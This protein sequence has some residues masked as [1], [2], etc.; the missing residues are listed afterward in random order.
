MEFSPIWIF[1]LV[2]LGVKFYYLYSKDKKWILIAEKLS[3]RLTSEKSL[4]SSIPILS[5]LDNKK[6]KGKKNGVS[7][8]IY[9]ET[10][11]SGK[12]KS[13]YTVLVA[14]FSSNILPKNLQLYHQG[15]FSTLNVKFL[16]GQDIQVGDKEFDEN[17]IIRGNEEREV[18]NFLTSEVRGILLN[19]FYQYKDARVENGSIHLDFYGYESDFTK[20]DSTLITMTD[21]I[22]QI[23]GISV[24]NEMK[25]GE[26]SSLPP[27]E[28]SSEDRFDLSD[29]F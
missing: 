29:R 2:I 20:I 21:L 9:T 8:E 5:F 19:F 23:Q 27:E 1:V 6:M 4:F 11:G 25:P 17:F 15:F 14:Y 26:D 18:T 10:R 16:G 22:N 24:G 3:F 13:T 28:G 12:N 7:C